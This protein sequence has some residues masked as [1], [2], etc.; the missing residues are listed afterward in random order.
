M[1]RRLTHRADNVWRNLS[2]LVSSIEN[3]K[4][5]DLLNTVK[6]WVEENERILGGLEFVKEH[7][8]LLLL[9]EGKASQFPINRPIEVAQHL[10]YLVGRINAYSKTCWRNG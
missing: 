9:L 5:Y 1:H 8:A 7:P 10:R 4:T 3:S 6:Q 2:N